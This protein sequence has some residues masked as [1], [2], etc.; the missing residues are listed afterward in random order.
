MGLLLGALFSFLVQFF[1]KAFVNTAFKIAIT[2]LFI[3]IFVAA[4]YAYLLAA[5]A[6][7]K[8]LEATMPEIVVGVWGWVMPYN[9]NYCITSL[10]AAVILR[11]VSAQLIVLVKSKHNATISN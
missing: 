10:G 6:I 5:K 11:F 1:T 8:S 9:V 3:T 7:I 2:G 4:V